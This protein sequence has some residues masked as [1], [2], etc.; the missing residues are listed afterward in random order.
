MQTIDAVVDMHVP[1]R[2]TGTPR[3]LQ[4]G[5][6]VYKIYDSPDTWEFEG[7]G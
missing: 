2:D 1:L 3:L 6:S 4:P 5:E 7:V